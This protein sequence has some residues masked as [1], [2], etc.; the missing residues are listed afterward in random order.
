MKLLIISLVV[1]GVLLIGGVWFWLSRDQEPQPMVLENKPI[2]LGSDQKG[3]QKEDMESGT[4][5][6]QS[7]DALAQALSSVSDPAPLAPSTSVDESVVTPPSEA[8]P[9]PPSISIVDRLLG[10]GFRTPSTPRTIDTIVL[11]SSYNASGG[12]TYNLEKIIGQYE[13]YGVGA[14]YLID[15]SGQIYRLVPE[16]SIAYHAGESK[17]PDGRKNVNDFSIGIELVGT[18]E[19][20]F[21]DKQYTMTNDLIADIK[22]RYKIK[23][24][25][26]HG[27][28]APKRKT[29]P[30]KFDWKKLN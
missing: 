25:V 7:N 6:S 22:T 20:G 18:E 19:S 2:T 1:G 23:D 8:V 9:T 11:H 16:P 3:I 21:T 10:F 30:W 26:G 14:H 29:D 13:Q 4:V 12:D 27:D 28:I 15:R 24:I 17:M 5:A